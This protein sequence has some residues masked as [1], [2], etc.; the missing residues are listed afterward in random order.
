MQARLQAESA[1]TLLLA[2]DIAARM[3][4]RGERAPTPAPPARGGRRRRVSARRSWRAPATRSS[5]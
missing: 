2:G 5:G 3:G 4:E 1:E